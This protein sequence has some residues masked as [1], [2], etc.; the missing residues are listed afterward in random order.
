VKKPKTIFVA[1]LK[2]RLDTYFKIVVR[3]V[4]DS[5]PKIIGNF[6]VRAAQDHMQLEIFKKLGQMSDTVNRGLGEVFFSFQI[7]QN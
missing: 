3:N 1:E 2:A 5:I 6:L 7:M 4:R